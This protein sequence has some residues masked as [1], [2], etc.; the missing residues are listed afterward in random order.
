MSR[1]EERLRSVRR[2]PSSVTPKRSSKSTDEP[3]TSSMSGSSDTRVPAARAASSSSNV[4][5]LENPC[6]PMISRC[7]PARAII[8]ST[9]GASTRWSACAPTI[10]S[11]IGTPSTSSDGRSWRSKIVRRRMYEACRRRTGSARAAAP[12]LIDPARRAARQHSA[13]DERRAE[14]E[15]L[16]LA[17]FAADEELVRRARCRARAAH[18]AGRA[19]AAPRRSSCGCA[20]RRTRRGRG[21]SRPRRS[22][23]PAA[24]RTASTGPARP[25]RRSPAG[26]T[27]GRRRRRARACAAGV[28]R[29]W[30]S[31][32]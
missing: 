27:R 9:A 5:A 14:D 24:A 1:R 23:G 20:G 6:G 22:P 3:T 17:G 16:V 30:H 4:I 18:R 11:V 21:S 7:A 15:R 29:G 13:D 12:R 25:A 10:T 8:S 2:T 32:R 26:P 31:R 19:A 28:A